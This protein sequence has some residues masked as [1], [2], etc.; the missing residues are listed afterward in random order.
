MDNNSS[1]FARQRIRSTPS[2]FDC[3]TA[4]NSGAYCTQILNNPVN[5]SGQSW[6]GTCQGISGALYRKKSVPATNIYLVL[7][8]ARNLSICL[9]ARKSGVRRKLGPQIIDLDYHLD[10]RHLRQK[11]WMNRNA[12]DKDA[13]VRAL[14][15]VGR[16]KSRNC[17]DTLSVSIKRE[18]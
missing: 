8:L 7:S 5:G 1:F 18:N 10:A 2:S 9:V 14:I 6:R 12:H 17:H 15:L 13:H 3:P 16:C 4:I 11:T